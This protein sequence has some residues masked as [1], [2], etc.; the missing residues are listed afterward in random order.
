MIWL[1]FTISIYLLQVPLANADE[2]QLLQRGYQL[3]QQ[4]QY[5]QALKVWATAL[6][7][8]D[9]P[10]LKIGRAHIRL[11]TSQRIA[12]Q[13]TI[14]SAMYFWGLSAE[15][16][17]P[18]KEA[19]EKEI[20]M[21]RP[22]V[23]K[24]SYK[25]WVELLVR[26][27]AELYRQLVLFWQNQDPTPATT[28]NERLIEHWERIAY[29]RENFTRKDDPPYETD[30]RGPVYV[31][32]GKSDRKVSGILN[33]S[34][35]EVM[36]LCSGT[37]IPCNPEAMA[38]IVTS[39][40]TQPHYEIW[41]Y[42]RPNTGMEYNLVHIFGQKAQGGFSQLTTIEDFIPSRAFSFSNRY[43]FQ[44]LTGRRTTPS[45][46]MTP[47]MIMQY[48]YYKQ[49]A[50]KDFYFSDQF[51]QLDTEWNRP[52]SIINPNPYIGKHA[53]PRKELEHQLATNKN[54]QK[55]PKEIST[56]EKEFP[57]IP[58]QVYQYR[59]L[60]ERNEPVFVT[61]LESNPQPSF[62]KD[63]AV[64]QDS[65]EAQISD[66]A[67]IAILFSYYKLYH[68]LQ[69]KNQEGHFLSQDRIS[70]DLLLDSTNTEQSS[71]VFWTPYVSGNVRQI[72]YAELHNL[73][74]NSRPSIDT[75]FPNSLR[76]LGRKE[77]EQPEPLHTDPNELEMGDLIL[78]YQMQT[79]KE[80]ALFPFVVT[81][82]RK[83][84]QDDDLVI[85]VEVY[86]LQKEADGIARFELSYE[87]LPVNWL[88]WTKERKQEF[89]LTLNIE[90]DQNRYSEN[91]QIKTRQLS[92]GRYVL[93]MEASDPTI[94][95]SVKKDIE[96][97][98]VE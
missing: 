74:S 59:L 57:S 64:N 38:N 44:S 78:G 94:S 39:L 1:V 67:S 35:G 18:N 55:A 13:Y 27:K 90:S 52:H 58:I 40:H 56:Y 3:E 48:I 86:H 42:N 46:V 83:I 23:G 97:E 76:G 50:T 79:E 7:T 22:L 77:I 10:S 4:K 8:L 60:N 20:E 69:L 80:N 95:Q 34:R 71:S 88:G 9:K 36:Q 14:A 2:D 72:L 15:D 91:L 32:Y 73:H 31:R 5:E 61:F 19:L 29:A 68:G 6:S 98:I 70:A 66:S 12:H 96:F 47:G 89:N 16:I 84:P 28:Y 45:D 51:S 43:D 49:L 26:D 24:Q 33:V 92:P 63:F 62:V 53:G 65:M 25:T 30:D 82:N 75:P 41:I 17:D 93:R 54:L 85:H 81:N 87:L 11:A 21:L 37:D